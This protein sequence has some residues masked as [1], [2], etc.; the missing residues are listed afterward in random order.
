LVHGKEQDFA[1]RG[2]LRLQNHDDRSPVSI[3]DIFVREPP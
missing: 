2:D 3:R 1:P